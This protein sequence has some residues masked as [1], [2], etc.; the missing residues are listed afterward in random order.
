MFLTF[1]IVFVN[2]CEEKN[3]ILFCVQVNL[4]F[5]KVHLVHLAMFLAAPAL[6]TQA[7]IIMCVCVCVCVCVCSEVEHE[8]SYD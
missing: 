8:W 2:S 1:S 7:E 4:R 6:T 5:V 3:Q